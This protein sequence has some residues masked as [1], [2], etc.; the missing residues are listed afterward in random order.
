MHAAPAEPTAGSQPRNRRAWARQGIVPASTSGHSPA[1]RA[2]SL[3]NT[4]SAGSLRM[5]PES[6][7]GFCTHGYSPALEGTGS[8]ERPPDEIRENA[9]RGHRMLHIPSHHASPLTAR[10]G[11]QLGRCARWIAAAPAGSESE[12]N[13]VGG[14]CFKIPG[15]QT[16][17]LHMPAANLV[18]NT[19]SGPTL[20]QGLRHRVD[21]PSTRP[22][23]ARPA[24]APQ[25]QTH[26][27]H[28]R[29]L[30]VPRPKPIRGLTNVP[31][32][33]QRTRIGPAP[34]P[35]AYRAREKSAG[36]G[37]SGLTP[38]CGACFDSSRTWMAT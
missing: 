30:L 19:P 14:P 36:S 17:S 21:V 16:G 3:N 18:A 29:G 9:P 38:A 27:N 32:D 4:Q 20:R 13:R 1:G 6:S 7:P 28:G 31:Y 15:V 12:Q 37:R 11:I 5:A 24:H 25:R 10:N 26:P 34:D 23:Q 22:G 8:M 2:S 33:G 35:P